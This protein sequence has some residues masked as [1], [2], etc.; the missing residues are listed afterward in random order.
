MVHHT[1]GRGGWERRSAPPSVLFFNFDI[2]GDFLKHEHR[3]GLLEGVAPAL[4]RGG[5]VRVVGLTS[6]SGSARHNL[7]LSL[8]RA[9][10][11][12][13]FL[14]GAV[15]TGFVAQAVVGFGEMKA[16]AEGHPDGSEHPRFR[17]VILFV[18]A[19]RT[20]PT[21]PPT[22]DVSPA[23]LLVDQLFPEDDMLDPASKITDVA[24]G[25][26]GFTELVPL[27]LAAAVGGVLGGALTGLS[28]AALMPLTWTGLHAQNIANGR[29]EGYVDA[30]QS[31][32]DAF[33][34]P[35][36]RSIPQTRWPSLPHPTP[37]PFSPAELTLVNQREWMAGRREGCALAYELLKKLDQV[38]LH[39]N[40]A[41]VNGR[42]LLV[43]MR[44]RFGGEGVK[45]WLMTA[46]NRRLIGGG[47]GTWP[48]RRF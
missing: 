36:L 29:I 40:N 17:S 25:A 19:G 16:R 43:W 41:V 46:I 21:P 1:T 28:A 35:A 10:R 27:E 3:V 11:T 20:P 26:L 34:S 42:Q 14:R 22:V 32:A 45:P 44:A 38:P 5:S 8:R 33:A 6:R 15:P 39:R 7:H 23:D 37:R 4:Q 18:G 48:L 47:S 12:V 13:A 2:D 30:V 24:I 9:E 31:M